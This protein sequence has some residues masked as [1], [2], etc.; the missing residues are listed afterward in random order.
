MALG[1][2][3]GRLLLAYA[4]VYLVWG[5][6]YLFIKLAVASMPALPMAGA[7]NL[8][9]G[10]L[11]VAATLAFTRAR[12]TAT[13]WRAAAIVGVSLM[14][15]NAAVAYAITRIPSGAAALLTAMTP[16]WIVL[17]DWMRDRR[18]RPH[19]ATLAGVFLGT[20]GIALL[21]GPAE[22]L[23]ADH[24]D[25]LG[26]AAVLGGS[27]VW[28]AGSLYSR[29]A[30]RPTSTQL[31]AG[32]QM[33]CGGAMLFGAAGLGGQWRGF[34]PATVTAQS[35]MAFAVLVGLASIAAFTAYAYLLAHATAARATTYAFV[36]PVVAVALGAAFGGEPLTA[37]TGLAAAI[38]VSGVAMIVMAP[39]VAAPT[40]DHDLSASSGS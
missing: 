6:S 13:H 4:T 28:A 1:T 3:R 21:V 19:G 26:A 15:S 23:G 32:M 20:L 14:S 37:R 16:C 29:H 25:L 30:P 35:W 31:V 38:I 17:F 22:L 5:S 2:P 9:A 34:D 39:A 18:H 36:N 10:T 12:A 24:I 8:L 7:R 33:A 40:P 27:A 11:L